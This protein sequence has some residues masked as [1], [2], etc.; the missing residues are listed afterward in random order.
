VVTTCGL[1]VTATTLKLKD[2]F[3]IAMVILSA[4]LSTKS[5]KPLLVRNFREISR[6]RIEGLLTL[7][8]KLTNTKNNTEK[9]H[10]FVETDTVR[11][12]YQP[13]ETV[14]VILITTKNSNIVED[15]DTLQ[16]MTRIVWF[17]IF[18]K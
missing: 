8:P 14:F 18:V 4:A 16:T 11:F 7:F 15:L 9:Q 3:C 10:T 5:G 12:V 13:L 2:I 1:L 17:N 6:S